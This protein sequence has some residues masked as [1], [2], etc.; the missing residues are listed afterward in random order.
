MSPSTMTQRH[1]TSSIY[2]PS[3]IYWLSYNLYVLILYS[4]ESQTGSCTVSLGTSTYHCQLSCITLCPCLSWHLNYLHRR[5]IMT[6]ILASSPYISFVS[7]HINFSRKIILPLIPS[8][9]WVDMY[10]IC[11]QQKK[12]SSCTPETSCYFFPKCLPTPT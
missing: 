5:H 6:I 1:I 2:S 3:M 11:Y 9:A 4:P 8:C 10:P 12:R 7:N